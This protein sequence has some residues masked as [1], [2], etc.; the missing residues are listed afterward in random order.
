MLHGYLS[1]ALLPIGWLYSTLPLLPVM[2]LFMRKVSV[3]G[4]IAA[5]SFIALLLCPRFGGS[6]PKYIVGAILLLGVCFVADLLAKERERIGVT[7]YDLGRVPIQEPDAVRSSASE[8]S[9][10]RSR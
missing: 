1:V 9:G 5:F 2:L 7:G 6:S 3:A 8:T 4:G 10:P